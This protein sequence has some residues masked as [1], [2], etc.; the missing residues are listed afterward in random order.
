[1]SKLRKILMLSDK[2]YSDLK[3]AIAACT[4]TN[5]AMMIPYAI[6]VRLVMELIKPI[7]GGEISW[8]AMWLL[9]A[10]GIAGAAVVFFC[11]KNDYRKTYVASYMESEK[12]RIT[13]AEHIRKLPM[14]VFNSKDLTELC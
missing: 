5:F 9:F 13:L 3:K 8:A 6:M 10:A 7:D 4:L 1:M 2:G 14:S 11:S 12:T